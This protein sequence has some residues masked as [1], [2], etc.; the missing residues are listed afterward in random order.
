M[1]H[2]NLFL[3][4]DPVSIPFSHPQGPSLAVASQFV[5]RPGQVYYFLDFMRRTGIRLTVDLADC[6][7]QLSGGLGLEAGALPLNLPSQ[8]LWQSFCIGPHSLTPAGTD[9]FLVGLRA[10]NRFISLDLGRKSASLL[11]PEVNDDFLSSSNWI[12]GKS[13]EVWFASWNLEDSVRR[14]E[15]PTATVKVRIWRYCPI[16]Q[17]TRQ[18]WKGEG[19]D[20]LHQLNVSDDGRFLVLC[21][22]G[23]RPYAAVPPGHPGQYPAEWTAFLKQ[24][25]IPSDTIVVDLKHDRQWRLPLPVPTAAHVE[26]DPCRPHRCYVSC[27]NIGLVGSS[28]TLFGP[29]GLYCF[30]LHPDG[31]RAVGAYSATDFYRITTHHVFRHQGRTLIGVTGFPD[32]I[33]LIDAETMTLVRK[34]KLFDG[35]PVDTKERP[36]FC[37]QEPRSPYSLHATADGNDMYVVGSGV[38]FVLDVASGAMKQLP[39]M[40]YREPDKEVITGH[41]TSY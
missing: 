24:G 8:S 37:K 21:E 7:S 16:Q 25:V 10:S 17:V 29:G 41:V 18:V 2:D 14:I 36:H 3:A 27:H 19:G 1:K 30:E 34:I 11:D 26:F 40:F 32:S 4:W 39:W 5:D 6:V 13:G 9:L 35:E 20:F 23:M 15:Q 33:F 38:L 12:V 28:N 22:M 31:P